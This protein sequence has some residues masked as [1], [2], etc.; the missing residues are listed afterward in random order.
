MLLEERRNAIIKFVNSLQP[1]LREAPPGCQVLE[2]QIVV[3]LLPLRQGNLLLQVG[4]GR[5]TA[6]GDPLTALPDALALPYGDG[7]DA[8]Q[9]P[10]GLFDGL[11]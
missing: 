8:L 3:P 7:V 6:R 4:N 2:G 9:L 10:L 5:R 11:K 1:Q